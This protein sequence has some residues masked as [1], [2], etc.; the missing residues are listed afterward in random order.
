[1]ELQGCRS[2]IFGVW[3]QAVDVLKYDPSFG[4]NLQKGLIKQNFQ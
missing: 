2:K 1:M 4:V 3:T